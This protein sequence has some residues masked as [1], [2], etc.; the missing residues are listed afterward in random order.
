ML[1]ALAC[2]G[3]FLVSTCQEKEFARTWRGQEGEK[4]AY[5]VPFGLLA[6][7]SSSTWH[8]GVLPWDAERR[9]Q[10]KIIRK[11]APSSRPPRLSA[12]VSRTL[13][14]G[15]AARLGRE[16]VVPGR[17]DM[18]ERVASASGAPGPPA[19]PGHARGPPEKQGR[20]AE[21]V[22][23]SSR[24]QRRSGCERVS[25]PR[26][27]GP[28]PATSVTAMDLVSSARRGGEGERPSCT[29]SCRGWWG[30]RCPMP[31]TYSRP[32][33]QRCLHGRRGEAPCP[34]WSSLEGSV[35][36]FPCLEDRLGGTGGLERTR[37]DPPHGI[38]RSRRMHPAPGPVG[39][40]R[41][42]AAGHRARLAPCVPRLRA[43]TA[44]PPA[45]CKGPGDV[46]GGRLREGSC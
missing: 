25:W 42:D 44:R 27:V 7:L 33:V 37:S 45:R 32:E 12:A 28:F 39:N 16:L 34:C 26:G 5:V 24:R 10:E 35:P 18:G 11:K 40:C 19:S 2:T 8:P 31:A 36:Q 29:A 13:T 17:E 9:Q 6:L 46:L 14:V 22:T 3:E 21:D 1:Q 4:R 38:S 41:A 43:W 30:W 23:T 20:A 15:H